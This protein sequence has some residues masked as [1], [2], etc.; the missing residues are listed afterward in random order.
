MNLMITILI[1]VITVVR[2]DLSGPH[3]VDG[4]IFGVFVM[5]QFRFDSCNNLL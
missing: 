2:G 1:T 4:K 3:T 5:V